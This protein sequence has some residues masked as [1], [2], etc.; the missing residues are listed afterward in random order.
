VGLTSNVDSGEERN[1]LILRKDVGSLDDQAQR[2]KSESCI[3]LTISNKRG[4][5][6]TYSVTKAALGGKNQ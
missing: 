5:C 1:R 2:V 6:V 3:S 4:G